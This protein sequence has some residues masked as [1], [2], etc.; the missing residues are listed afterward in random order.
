M[1]RRRDF[2]TMLGGAAATWP[3]AARAQQLAL[4]VV[5]HLSGRSQHDSLQLLP[6]FRQGLKE[7]GFV[8]GRNVAIEYRWEKIKVIGCRRWRPIWFVSG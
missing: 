8:E 5:G 2:I 3:L 4:P 6:A 1:M 7:V